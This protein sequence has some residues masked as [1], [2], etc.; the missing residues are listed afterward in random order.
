LGIAV[1][2]LAMTSANES[3]RLILASASPRRK[4]LLSYLGLAFTIH[5]SAIEEVIDPNLAPCEVVSQLA[6]AKALDVA[7]LLAAQS[8]SQGINH[9][10]IGADTIVVCNRRTL[11][12]PVDEKEAQEML[13]YLSGKTHQVYTGV[14]LVCVPEDGIALSTKTVSETSNVTFR[15]LSLAEIKAYV[16]TK[17][18]MDKAGSYALQGTGSAFVRSIDGCYTNVI[19]LP[20]PKLVQLLR[21]AGVNVLGE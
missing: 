1:G 17:E 10:V 14:A 13:S 9:L 5:P 6:L 15:T 18:P 11:G 16:A 12:K 21:E 7:H 20:I 4:E 3:P 2:Q 19:G 8:K